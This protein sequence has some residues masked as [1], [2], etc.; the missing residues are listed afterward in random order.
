MRVGDIEQR[1]SQRIVLAEA[2]C[3]EERR[4][5]DRRV[6]AAQEAMQR[7]VDSADRA[8]TQLFEAMSNAEQR[9]SALMAEN[10]LLAE[11]LHRLDYYYWT[12]L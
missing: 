8:Q 4:L 2:Q 7:A 12:C 6:Q 9:N 11:G 10:T 1:C 3:R 5:A